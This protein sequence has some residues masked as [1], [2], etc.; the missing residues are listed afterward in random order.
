MESKMGITMPNILKKKGKSW[1]LFKAREN[2]RLKLQMEALKRSLA[3]QASTAKVLNMI[4]LPPDNMDEEE[5]FN[6]RLEFRESELAGNYGSAPKEA[7]QAF[8][9][10]SKPIFKCAPP[11]STKGRKTALVEQIPDFYVLSDNNLNSNDDSGILTQLILLDND[12]S[13]IGAETVGQQTLVKLESDTV[14]IIPAIESAEPLPDLVTME[15][16]V[17]LAEID[18]QNI[19]LNILTLNSVPNSR[20]LIETN[21]SIVDIAVSKSAYLGAEFCST[22]PSV[23]NLEP[24]LLIELSCVTSASVP[25]LIPKCSSICTPGGILSGSGLVKTF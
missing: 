8:Y 12:I 5:I 20:S 21:P 24:I 23:S 19:D 15:D 1:K 2:F 14:M 13:Q 17:Q 22:A 25:T 18:L 10:E 16:Q 7:V 11:P 4:E 9:G 3:E 6:D